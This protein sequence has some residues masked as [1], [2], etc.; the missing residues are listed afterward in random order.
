MKGQST[1]TFPCSD[2]SILG[3]RTVGGNGLHPNEASCQEFPS[4]TQQGLPFQPPMGQEIR[5]WIFPWVLGG[6]VG[7]IRSL[8]ALGE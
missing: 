2:K 6:S 7:I 4:V 1:G 8:G 5:K 3:G